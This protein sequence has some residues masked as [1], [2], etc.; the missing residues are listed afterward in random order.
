VRAVETSPVEHALDAHERQEQMRRLA[1]VIVGALALA[2]CVVPRPVVGPRF[3]GCS[4]SAAEPFRCGVSSVANSDGTYATGWGRTSEPATFIS[5]ELT[6]EQKRPDGTW[7]GIWVDRS[8]AGRAVQFRE[9]QSATID[10]ERGHYRWRVRVTFAG[11]NTTYHAVG[12]E[13]FVP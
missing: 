10:C 1:V 13:H 11:N 2:G 7:T 12:V 4:S 9:Y 8:G 5:I 6:L 3:E